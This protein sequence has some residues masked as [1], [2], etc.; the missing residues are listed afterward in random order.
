MIQD[1]FPSHFS[2]EYQI[3]T[4]SA[5]D[6]MIL[7][8]KNQFFLTSAGSYPLYEQLD[9]DEKEAHFLYLFSIDS[10][11][12]FLSDFSD[13]YMEVFCS[14][15]CARGILK[16]Y[17]YREIRTLRPMSLAF[18]GFTAWHLYSWY[19]ANRFC[20]HCGSKMIPGTNERKVVCPD[21]H[22]EVF[23]RINPAVIVAVHDGDR[24]LMT[25]YAG[26]PV[27]WFVLVAGF[28][29]IGE[30]AEDT[31]R[32]EVMEETG[33]KIKNIRYFGSQPWGVPG[34]LTLGFTAEL[35]GP[36]KITLDTGELAEG[37]W[38][39]REEVPVPDDDVSITAA[40]I[41]AFVNHE[42]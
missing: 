38:F 40:M 26:R 28:V 29:E 5:G 36:D 12:Y 4:P 41:L 25:K 2:L 23:P 34:N 35:D 39:R 6:I 37:R 9:F 8:H 22:A 17:T 32:R 31:V 24:L 30:T 1:I 13:S 11:K 33:V 27:G 19:Q 3:L 16:A 14:A 20:G 15:N 42:F 7:L 18:A 10:Q 21:C